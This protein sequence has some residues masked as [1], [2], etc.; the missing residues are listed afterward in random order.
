MFLKMLQRNLN[1]Q[2]FLFNAEG[3][4]S[5]GSGGAVDN[6][7]G[8]STELKDDASKQLEVFKAELQKLKEENESYKKKEQESHKQK[9]IDSNDLESL[10][11]IEVEAKRELEA[12][13][14]AIERKQ[15]EEK[16]KLVKTSMKQLFMKELGS[17]LHNPD[18]A[19]TL[20]QWD[21]FVVDEKSE[22][23]FNKDGVKQAVED[24]RSKH[25]YL[26]KSGDVKLP[27]NSA[28]SGSSKESFA[29]R[30]EKQSGFFGGKK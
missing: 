23:G 20:V 10:L 2:N 11:K 19:D 13:L 22:I 29:E 5:G 17:E 18:L 4:E 30:F 9:L 27:Q 25:S 14:E 1:P 7:G 21:K 15:I 28:K 26:L 12:K 3:E 8:E 24:F 16:T 6:A